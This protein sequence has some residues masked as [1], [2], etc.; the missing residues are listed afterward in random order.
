MAEITKALCDAI[1]KEDY[2]PDG[3]GNT[4]Y[5]DNAWF[6]MM[7]KHKT[8]GKHYDFPVQYGYA[9]NASHTASTALNKTNTVQ[10]VE[11][12]VTTVGDYDAKSI[13]L[14][15]LAEATDEGAFVDAL[16]NTVD[17]LIKA[18]SNRAGQ[19]A[20]GN[21]G[22]A[23]GQVASVST[24]AV[25]LSNIDDVTNFEVG[26]EIASSEADGLTGSLQTGTATIT[27]IDRAT[28]TLTTDSNWTAQIA[29]LDADDYLFA[30]GDFGIGRAGLS[31][32][33]PVTRTGLGTAF[34]GAT[35]SVD[36]TR[37]A[38]QVVTGTGIPIS[39]G[40]R[41]GAAVTG[42][43]EGKPDTALMSFETY[44][45]LV[46]ELDAKVQYCKTDSKGM[47]ASIGFDGI[48]I[49][50]GRGK[51]ECY[52]DRSCPSNRIYL[53]KKDA[54]KAIHSQATPIKI[55]D[56]D[57]GMLSREASSF[58]FDVRGSSLLNFACTKPAS[59]CV[60]SI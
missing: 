27:A 51:I 46:T 54:W 21:R 17:S 41:K 22:A 2:G 13:A 38:G 8:K 30:S 58:G 31:D 49:A 9:S 29:S 11:F 26:M 3:V 25:V 37:L 12:N 23:L 43:E 36:E 56:E 32:W 28:G 6:G 60:V 47:D 42:R 55:M 44:N 35:R 5:E 34:Y 20:F 16:R 4:A 33:C 24:T 45:D 50:G 40:I 1:L 52:P 19:H 14:Q 59:N 18:L 7:P 10:F 57:G 39:H 53:V 48:S 15:T